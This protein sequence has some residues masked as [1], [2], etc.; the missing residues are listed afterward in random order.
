[1]ER[2]ASPSGPDAHSWCRDPL[3]VP[4][5]E[6]RVP[7]G[8]W[9]VA[10]RARRARRGPAGLGRR[11]GRGGKLSR[12]RPGAGR[13]R[14]R[15][16]LGGVAG[17]AARRGPK[18]TA[19]RARQR[20]GDP[21]GPRRR[22]HG[23]PEQKRFGQARR[24]AVRRPSRPDFGA[25]HARTRVP[26]ATARQ[27]GPLTRTRRSGTVRG[28][29]PGDHAAVIVSHID[30]AMWPSHIDLAMWPSRILLGMWPSRI[31]A[32][33]ASPPPGPALLRARACTRA[34]ADP[35]RS[36]TRACAHGE[37]PGM[38]MLL[39]RPG[40]Q[41]AKPDE[42]RRWAGAAI[43]SGDRRPPVATA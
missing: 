40:D 30:L 14:R 15:G 9:R 3:R 8:E 20:G 5:A 11:G 12:P 42:A 2:R 38:S 43:V 24:R 39:V 25:I 35:A 7:S 10:R 26:S 27:S 22:V 4:S 37:C 16:G 1:M 31:L 19:G 33:R 34:C 32:L 13:A 29:A 36:C 6:C 21:S 41:P 28:T 17:S 18:S 23:H